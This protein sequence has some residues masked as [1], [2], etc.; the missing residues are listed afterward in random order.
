MDCRTRVVLSYYNLSFLSVC[1]VV[2]LFVR[3]L[4]RGYLTDLGHFRETMSITLSISAG[5]SQSGNPIG[6]ELASIRKY[7]KCRV[8]N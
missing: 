8:T 5:E 7:K 6:S 1:L 3:D 2:W 4:L